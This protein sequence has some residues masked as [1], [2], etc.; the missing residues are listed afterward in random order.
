[1]NDEISIGYSCTRKCS[2]RERLPSVVR[3]E[4]LAP[5]LFRNSVSTP[6]NFIIR[7]Y[8]SFYD[9]HNGLILQFLKEGK[10]LYDK[11]DLSQSYNRL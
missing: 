2:N 5:S 6:V 10:R 3:P 4:L 9:S 1:M 8:H 7:T 11:L